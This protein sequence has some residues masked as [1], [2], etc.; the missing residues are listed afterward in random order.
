M[1]ILAHQLQLKTVDRVTFIID[2]W[3]QKDKLLGCTLSEW[4]IEKIKVKHHKSGYH[5]VLDMIT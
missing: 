2:G 3:Q 4:P 5:H 1:E